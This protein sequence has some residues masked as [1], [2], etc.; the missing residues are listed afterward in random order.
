MD[1]IFSWDTYG[2]AWLTTA[3]SAIVLLLVGYLATRL[4]LAHNRTRVYESGLYNC[5][6]NYLECLSKA[7]ERLRNLRAILAQVRPGPDKPDFN[8]ICDDLYNIVGEEIG[9]IESQLEAMT[10]TEDRAWYEL[11]IAWRPLL[12]INNHIAAMAEL[13]LEA[14]T[15]EELE[16]RKKRWLEKWE[17]EKEAELKKYKR[18]IADL[19]ARI[20]E[21]ELQLEELEAL[22]GEVN[23]LKALAHE[24]E[25]NDAEE[26]QR[27]RD[28]LERLKKKDSS[29]LDEEIAARMMAELSEVGSLEQAEAELAKT[30][31]EMHFCRNQLQE[32][33]D[34]AEEAR[35]LQAKAD[36]MAQKNRWWTLVRK[37]RKQTLLLDEYNTEKMDASPEDEERMAAIRDFQ[38]MEAKNAEMRGRISELTTNN[39]K[40]TAQLEQFNAQAASAE[41]LRHTLHQVE[42]ARKNTQRE[43]NSLEQMVSQMESDLLK[44]TTENRKLAKSEQKL[45]EFIQENRV[46]Q[47]DLRKSES[48]HLEKI[49]AYEI[50][51]DKLQAALKNAEEKLNSQ[52]IDGMVPEEEVMSLQNAYD[53]L[54]N[55]VIQVKGARV[56]AERGEKKA[57]EELDKMQKEFKALQT[58]YRELLNA[59]KQMNQEVQKK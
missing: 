11:E 4:Q 27:L 26:I 24:N 12:D 44:A 13:L 1:T 32:I 56:Q 35:R 46:L 8:D 33:K 41:E 53:Q 7:L 2:D 40:L 14:I 45:G 36:W 9:L 19:K 20:R 38:E 21:Y 15:E 16:E 57:K 6:S 28:E 51:L 29:E 10:E 34:D 48:K 5:W 43:L 49:A 3:L 30:Q 47:E 39:R 25:A 31:G 18:Q 23:R 17:T 55:Q 22:R 42:I 59:F 52:D 37:N 58:K 54:N 50:E